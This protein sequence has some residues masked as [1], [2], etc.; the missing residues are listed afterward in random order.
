MSAR[1]K[2][3][4]T[5]LASELAVRVEQVRATM[6]LLG[7]GATIPFIARYRKEATGGLDDGQL[8]QLGERLGYLRDLE[9]RRETVLA[10]IGEQGKLTPELAAAIEA[11]ETKQRLED[12]YLPY[13]PKRRTKAQ[14]AR[15]AGLEPLALKL[16]EQP[17]LDPRRAAAAFLRP[18]AFADVEAALEGARQI[19][20]ERW[21]EDS[22][23]LGEVRQGLWEHGYLASKLV[24]GKQEEG[25]KFS[26]YFEYHERLNRIPSHRALALE[27]GESEGILRLA[28]ISEA[29]LLEEPKQPSRYEGVIARRVGVRDRGRP[30][31]AWLLE[32]VGEAWRSKLLPHMRTEL[33][34]KM[35]EQAQQEAIK[36]FGANLSDLL[37]APPAGE[38]ATLGIDPGLRT[39]CKLAVVDATGKLLAHETI[40]PHPP[41]NRLSDALAALSRLCR[42]HKVQLIAIGNG[43]ASRETDRMVSELIAKEPGLG[44]QKVLVS[45]AG[46]S[47]YSASELAAAEFPELDVSVRGAVSIARRLQDPLAE[48]VKLDP[49]AI[50]VGQYQHDVDQNALAQRLDGVVESCVNRVGVDLNTASAP[51]LARVSGLNRSLAANIVAHRDSHGRF[52]NRQAL[53]AVPRM[54]A[55]TFQQC[56]GFLRIRGGSQPLDA[57]AV[58]PEA[59]EV[60][61]RIA[62]AARCSVAELIGASARLGGLEA[63]NFTDARFGL[64]TVIDIFAELEKPS[65]DPRGSF[66]TASFREDVAEIGDLEIGMALEG[67]VS[68]VTNFG[69]FVD[70]GV[71]QDGLVHISQLADRFVADPRKVVKAGDVV[72]VRVLEV[73]VKRRRIALTMKTGSA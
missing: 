4:E 30:A 13:K 38:R 45:E 37:L 61:G 33:F 47:V 43:T 65:R 40:Y 34:G 9:D 67:V 1:E 39:G 44:L 2:R 55:K 36:V 56:A 19:L 15:E 31:D 25:A 26:D 46:A 16:W 69:A 60:V 22:E 27:R 62:G 59:Y 18:P 12:L 3:I 6:A 17:Q 7:E 64:P 58:H 42:R 73:D 28:L 14:I 51:L 68:N 41:A 8:R 57:S 21:S 49:K 32:T 53:M 70:I 72:K 54:G 66:R 71:H 24:R 52:D 50:G 29:A 23:L 10:S 20:M 48:L 11:A 5:V 35:R 63:R